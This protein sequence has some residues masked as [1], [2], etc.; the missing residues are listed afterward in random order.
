MFF[1]TSV[2][3]HAVIIFLAKE[4]R[5]EGCKGYWCTQNARTYFL[6]EE[7]KD[8]FWAR[9]KVIG[10]HRMHGIHRNF[11]LTQRAQGFAKLVIN[12]ISV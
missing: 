2:K 7:Q 3:K 6:T 1:C 9:T 8:I 10:A 11:I 12:W 4:L 5:G